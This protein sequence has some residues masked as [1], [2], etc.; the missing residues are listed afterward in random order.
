MLFFLRIAPI[1][2]KVNREINSNTQEGKETLIQVEQNN[3]TM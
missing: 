2:T 3:I 1:E